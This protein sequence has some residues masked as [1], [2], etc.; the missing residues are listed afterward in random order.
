MNHRLWM[1]GALTAIT[2][3]CGQPLA[4]MDRL[5]AAVTAGEQYCNWTP[6][7]D[8]PR[9]FDATVGL[10]IKEAVAIKLDVY[11]KWSDDPADEKAE[12]VPLNGL[13]SAVSRAPEI[14][15]VFSGPDGTF[16]VIARKPGKAS[17]EFHIAGHPGTIIAPITVTPSDEFKNIVEYDPKEDD[18]DDGGTTQ[19]DG[20]TSSNQNDGSPSDQNDGG[21]EGGQP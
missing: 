19:T 15:E 10:E 6:Y 21:V 2:F 1:S 14:V 13:M 7:P 11:P 18:E 12:E 5:K 16:A 8:N 20:G 4:Q 17:L 9:D 3:A